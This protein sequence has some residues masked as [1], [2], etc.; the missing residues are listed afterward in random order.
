MINDICELLLL[1]PVYASVNEVVTDIDNVEII[2]DVLD[3]IV[4]E[5]DFGLGTTI[6]QTPIIR[7]E[8]TERPIVLE[9]M[10]SVCKPFCCVPCIYFCDRKSN[11]TKHHATKKH[12]DKIRNT[13]VI[14]EGDFE[15][16]NCVKSYKSYQGLWAH[17]KKCKPIAVVVAVPETDLHAKINNLERI[18]L[19]MAKN[20]QP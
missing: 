12:I 4:V 17:N 13:E 7:I 15:C 16:K 5:S 18:I 6:S 1:E 9:P 2:S 11:L 19:G 8:S 20:Q 14:V 10:S 3:K